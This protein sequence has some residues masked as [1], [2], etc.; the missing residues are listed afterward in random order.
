LAQIN[1]HDDRIA[2]ALERRHLFHGGLYGDGCTHQS[3]GPDA[4]REVQ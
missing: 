2:V 4:T 3:A 1:L